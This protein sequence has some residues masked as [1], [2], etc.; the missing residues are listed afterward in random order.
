M[1]TTS[2][3]FSEVF[4]LGGCPTEVLKM[5]ANVEDEWNVA[6]IIVP[7]NPGIVD[8]YRHLVIHLHSHFGGAFPVLVGMSHLLLE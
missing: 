5:G 4:N 8:F 3:P 2:E 7:G 1:G 6:I